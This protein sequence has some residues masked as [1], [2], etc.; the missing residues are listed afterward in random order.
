MSAASRWY[1]SV[2]FMFPQLMGLTQHSIARVPT[3]LAARVYSNCYMN[4][5]RTP[6][7][8]GPGLSRLYCSGYQGDNDTV[9]APCA[10]MRPKTSAKS[11]STSKEE[12]TTEKNKSTDKTGQGGNLAEDTWHVPQNNG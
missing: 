6:A 1:G 8:G 2:R 11:T 7:F 5:G 3:L 12:D 9:L 10:Y 4:V